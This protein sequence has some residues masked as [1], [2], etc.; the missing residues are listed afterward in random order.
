MTNETRVWRENW[1]RVKQERTHEERQFHNQ[2]AS[3]KTLQEHAK[4]RREQTL[5]DKLT[6]FNIRGARC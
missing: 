5:L 1:Q 6:V 3:K 4:T 2:T